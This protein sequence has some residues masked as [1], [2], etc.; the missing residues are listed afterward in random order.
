VASGFLA[1]A[2]ILR[3]QGR[4]GEVLALSLSDLPA[5]FENLHRAFLDQPAGP[6]APVTVEDTWLHK[7]KVVLKLAGVDSID[8][9]ESLRGRYLLIPREEKIPLPAGQYYLWELEGCRVVVQEAAGERTLGTVTGIEH[10]GGAD[11][12]HVSDGSR[13][14]LIPLAASICKRIDPA[15]KLIVVDPPEDLLDLN[16]K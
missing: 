3:P 9:A 2:C 15:G 14:A 13:E 16:A 12:L 8:S 10:A 5:R 7:G 4:R 11:L 1:I 6:P